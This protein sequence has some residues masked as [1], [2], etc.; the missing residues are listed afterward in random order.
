MDEGMMERKQWGIG[1]EGGKWNGEE[2][3][4][5]DEDEGKWKGN[6]EW[7][8]KAAGGGGKETSR[9]SPK[10]KEGNGRF[11]QLQSPSSLPPFGSSSHPAFTLFSLLSSTFSHINN[12]LILHLFLFWFAPFL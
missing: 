4:G 9:S 5:E 3:E 8:A 12:G 10:R 2:E 1:K 7:R 11:C 6:L